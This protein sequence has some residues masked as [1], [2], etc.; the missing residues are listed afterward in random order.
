MKHR[1]ITTFELMKRWG[2]GRRNI[3]YWC[4]AGKLKF[5]KV[6][7]R[8]LFKR[9]VVKAFEVSRHGEFSEGARIESA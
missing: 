5:H 8:R 6:G 4:S 3:D 1:M 9:D 7:K 2:I